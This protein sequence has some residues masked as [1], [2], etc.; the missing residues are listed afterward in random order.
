MALLSPI[1]DSF[2][3]NL[4]TDFGLTKM[5][6]NIFDLLDHTQTACHVH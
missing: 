2:V 5:T 6:N 3:V 4:R 1:P